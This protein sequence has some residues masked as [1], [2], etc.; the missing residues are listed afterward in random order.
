MSTVHPTIAWLRR[1]SRSIEYCGSYPAREHREENLEAM[2]ERLRMAAEFACA[3]E[4]DGEYSY[5]GPQR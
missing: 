5:G 4:Q 3:Q 2:R 1:L